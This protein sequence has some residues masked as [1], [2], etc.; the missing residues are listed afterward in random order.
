VVGGH[1]DDNLFAYLWKWVGSD[2]R[3]PNG[4][5]LETSKA[6]AWFGKAIL[7]HLGRLH[8]LDVEYANATDDARESFFRISPGSVH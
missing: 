2:T 1:D 8:R 6:A 4:D 3:Q 7:A 5:L